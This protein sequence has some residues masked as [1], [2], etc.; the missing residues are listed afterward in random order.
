MQLICTFVFAYAKS[1]L[2]HDMAHID[3]SKQCAPSSLIKVCTVYLSEWIFWSYFSV[4]S[5]N[6]LD[7]RLTAIF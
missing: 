2:S 3:L 4:G 5:G 6:R 1:R 7:I